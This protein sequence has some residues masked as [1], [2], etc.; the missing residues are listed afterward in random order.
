[1]TIHELCDCGES[2]SVELPAD[3][4]PPIQRGRL[5]RASRASGEEFD[6]CVV[7]VLGEAPRR[8]GAAYLRARLGGPRWKLL[9]SL[10]R[11]IAAGVVE[12]TGVTSGTR[13]LLRRAG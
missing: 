6:A 11:L 5:E 3:G 4:G 8:V 2:G 9:G 12:R 7:E 13:Y 10:R 1:M